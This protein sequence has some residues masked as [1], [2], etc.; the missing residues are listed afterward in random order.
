MLGPRPQE[1]WFLLLW[2]YCQGVNFPP[3]QPSLFQNVQPGLRIPALGIETLSPTGNREQLGGWTGKWQLCL[4]DSLGGGKRAPE[5]GGKQGLSEAPTLR[6]GLA[7]QFAGPDAKWNAGSFVLQKG[8]SKLL[9]LSRWWQQSIKPS[10]VGRRTSECKVLGTGHTSMK[11]SQF[12]CLWSWESH[13][14]PLA[15]GLFREGDS[16]IYVV[17]LCRSQ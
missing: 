2:A 8:E 12:H 5:F 10:G 14:P 16:S 11:P 3:P 7:S 9:R 17:R 15:P 6:A 1:L 4:L 13:W